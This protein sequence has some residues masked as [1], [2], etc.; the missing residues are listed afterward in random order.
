MRNDGWSRYARRRQ[1]Q[2]RLAVFKYRARFMN[3]QVLLSALA[4]LAGDAAAADEL[5]LPKSLERNQPA[6]FAYRFDEH[7]TGRGF[8][9][10][11]WSDVVGRI[12]ERR[13]I[14]VD[15]GEVPEVV[16]SLD[17]RRAVTTANQLVARLSFDGIDQ[18]GGN[19]HLEN[20]IS[21]P[22]IVPP[23]D[24]PWSDYQIIIW[25]GQTP[26][27]YAMLK[28]LGVTAGMV[29]ADHRD[30]ASTSMPS[31]ARLVDADLRCYLEN[32][33][34]DFYSPYHKW[35]D[36]RPVDWRFLEAKQ[37][38]WANPGDR[39][40]FI[41]EP[42]L[43]DPEWLNK[44]HD[45]LIRSVRA[46]RP[47]RPL[48][49]SLCDEAGIGDLTAFWDF[50]LS[51]FS[52]AAM[53]E[54]LKNNYDSLAALN[55]QWSTAFRGWDQVVPMTTDEAMRRSDENFSAWAD[56]KEW[57]D[58]A[59]A[60]A[61]KSGSDSVH[62]GDPGAVAAIEGAQIP[63]W[64]GYD[65][66]GHATSVDAIELYAHGENIP[67]ARSLNPQLILLTT[68]FGSGPSELHRVWR[69]LLRGTGGLLL[70][71]DKSEFVGKDGS[72]G[73]RGR[74][75]AP[76]FGEI[77]NGLGALLINS[78]RHTD[79]IGILYSPASRRVQWLLDRRAST[80]EWSRRGASTESQDD[81]IRTST[82]Q[83]A[84]ALEHMGL[85]HRFVS[86]EQV[87]RGEL[88]GDYR[89]LI[90]PHTIALGANEATEIRGFVERGGV[91]IADSEPGQFDEHGRRLTKPALSDIFAGPAT[92]SA[93][94]FAFGKGRAIYLASANGRDRQNTQRLSRILDN[95]GVKPPFPVLRADGEP[96]NNVETRIFTN[97]ALTIVALQRD[98]L[99]PSNS[100][101]HETV[102]LPLPRM[103]S[104]Y[105]LRARQLLG[106]TDRL[107]LELGPVEPVLL[108]L[109]KKPIAPP[110][111]AGPGRARL[112]E[113]AEFQVR[114]NSSAEHGVVHLDVTDPE[115][116][117]I[118]HYSEN[119]LIDGAAT[120]K[121]LPLALNDKP[122]V[123]RLRAADLP[124]DGT[125]TAE[126]QV[127][128]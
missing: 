47:Y 62:A 71:D 74:E 77:R 7:L 93:A 125:A 27:G 92:R 36:G 19:R 4:V 128:P 22:F 35:Y 45:R 51:D 116:G 32:I 83:F 76:Y 69:E 11:Q 97:G 99:P 56:F 23:A 103:F 17:L 75:A 110:S 34:T 64:D 87:W 14:P 70:W 29:Q 53:R 102:V 86:S 28:K 88:R 105:D 57:M 37:R 67:I 122:G 12:V 40:A 104:V 111:I 18:N 42:S 65:Y 58:V 120:T 60:R 81:V 54:W 26:A 24:H 95:A 15:L 84:H 3:L 41:R 94:S 48:Y 107:E 114:L 126:L 79:P 124:S 20:E 61:L 108:S 5:V 72:L 10:I 50:D 59:F 123:W 49:Y 127:D 21:T 112:G 118:A 101:T 96:A 43:S 2:V 78:R 119:L 46:L 90:L 68:S 8:L 33:S 13:R 98:Y 85:Q 16:F 117:T 89:V 30:E 6:D 100:S 38:Y 113:I 66:S 91:V 73:D 82:R 80:E 9:D 52:L 115:G 63:G 55:Q 44:I 39:A 25:Q 109:S 1:D 121:V 31:L 106:N